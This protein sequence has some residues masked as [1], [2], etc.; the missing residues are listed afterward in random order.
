MNLKFKN[1]FYP[2]IV[3]L[4]TFIFFFFF[5]LFIGLP[6]TSKTI[7]EFNNS[8]SWIFWLS[9]FFIY[10]IVIYLILYLDTKKNNLDSAKYF[11][12]FFVFLFVNAILSLIPMLI[13]ISLSGFIKGDVSNTVRISFIIF[14]YLILLW[15]LFV[16]YFNLLISISLEKE[17]IL[18][19]INHNIWFFIFNKINFKIKGN[20]LY[21]F[22]IKRKNLIFACYF[23][24]EKYHVIQIQFEDQIEILGKSKD[25]NKVVDFFVDVLEKN[26]NND[27][28][29]QKIAA[30]DIAK[31]SL[32]YLINNPS[33]YFIYLNN[34]FENLILKGKIPEKVIIMKEKNFVYQFKKI[35]KKI[36]KEEIN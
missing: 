33:N 24:D 8:Q 16:Y 14:I 23:I 17:K 21:E 32:D 30:D 2:L 27:N 13:F 9:F 34:N 1:I 15:F 3:W 31:I 11:K 7:L 6:F 5:I 19:I 25:K 20:L 18:Q 4:L 36:K 10:S 12:L 29:L 35:L 26:Q 28:N 22:E